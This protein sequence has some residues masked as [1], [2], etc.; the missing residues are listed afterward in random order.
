MNVCAWLPLERIFAH[1]K[2]FELC[3]EVAATEC[4]YLHR[5]CTDSAHSPEIVYAVLCNN[6]QSPPRQKAAPSLTTQLGQKF[7]DTATAPGQWGQFIPCCWISKITEIFCCIHFMVCRIS[8]GHSITHWIIT[9]DKSQM[10]TWNKTQ[11]DSGNQF[12]ATARFL[13][14]SSPSYDLIWGSVL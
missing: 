3:S 7:I 6:L 11:M 9:R 10:I 1:L 5:F 12:L 8:Q 2:Q 14:R 4:R 13:V